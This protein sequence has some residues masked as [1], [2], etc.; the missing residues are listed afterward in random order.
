MI[1]TLAGSAGSY[2][3]RSVALPWKRCKLQKNATNEV[4]HTET[5]Y[6][7]HVTQM[8][9]ASITTYGI[10]VICAMTCATHVTTFSL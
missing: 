8:H 4:L 3:R 5:V 9:V 7:M 1:F 2:M 10:T 6:A